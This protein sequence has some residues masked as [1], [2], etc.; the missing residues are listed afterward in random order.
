MNIIRNILIFIFLS[1]FSSVLKGLQNFEH[2]EEFNHIIDEI[3]RYRLNT[4]SVVQQET[5]PLNQNQPEEEGFIESEGYPSPPPSD[6]VDYSEDFFKTLIS[7]KLLTASEAKFMYASMDTTQ[8]ISVD[9]TLISKPTMSKSD[10]DKL[11]DY[12]IDYAYQYFEKKY[13]TSCFL[14][15]ATP[16]FNKNKTKLVLSIDYFCGPLYGHG[17]IFILNKVKGKWMIVEELGTWQSSRDLHWNF[18]PE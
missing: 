4:V 1:A 5:I 13:G 8:V 10:I 9:S 18:S 3:V 17:Y 14:R 15:I 11:F 12:D 2:H 16:L 7:N 6:M